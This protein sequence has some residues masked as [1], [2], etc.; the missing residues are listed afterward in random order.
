[1]GVDSMSLNLYIISL[2]KDNSNYCQNKEMYILCL[3]TEII[4]ISSESILNQENSTSQMEW[5][6]IFDE[7]AHSAI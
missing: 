7:L 3:N 1:M 5:R 2:Q 6:L 4:M